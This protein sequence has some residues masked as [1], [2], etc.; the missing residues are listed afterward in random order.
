MNSKINIIDQLNE[1]LTDLSEIRRMGK[2]HGE[3]EVIVVSLGS[4]RHVP[5]Y[6]N[7]EQELDLYFDK[8]HTQ[9]CEFLGE[10]IYN[11]AGALYE[12]DIKFPKK[13]FFEHQSALRCSWWKYE[14]IEIMLMLT[15]HDADTCKFIR[16]GAS[17]VEL[18]SE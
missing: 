2:D 9:L 18:N 5:Y 14:D 17:G 10:S 3:C 7:T 4:W 1:L 12:T 16:I 8:F 15:A 11:G 13:Y 6:V